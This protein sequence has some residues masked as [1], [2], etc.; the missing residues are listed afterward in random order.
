MNHNT[1]DTLK[2][3]QHLVT[4]LFYLHEQEIE[5]IPHLVSDLKVIYPEKVGS[6]T[7]N[8]SLESD[9]DP[10]FT[11]ELII[12]HSGKKDSKLVQKFNDEL[13]DKPLYFSEDD[14]ENFISFS[15]G[16]TVLKKKVKRQFYQSID[17]L[18]RIGVPDKPKLSLL[19]RFTTFLWK[20]RIGVSSTVVASLVMIMVI[21]S[22]IPPS[23]QGTIE[24]EPIV[25][26]AFSPQELVVSEPQ[27]TARTLRADLAKLGFVATLKSVNEGWMV[28]VVDL[29][30]GNPED[31][32]V[33][34]DEY[35]ELELPSPGDRSLRILVMAK[36]GE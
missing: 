5:E 19:S 13:N 21:I 10:S 1:Q 4:Q 9:L 22:I 31:L 16:M 30:T 34:L 35:E 25:R 23:E 18:E 36:K 6:K 15:E 12:D 29:S 17:G 33:L 11:Y 26:G 24:P 28:E 20:W 3:A 7:A 27:V 8:V 14:K 32:F 2:H